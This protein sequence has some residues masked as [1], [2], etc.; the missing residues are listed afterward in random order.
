MKKTNWSILAVFLALF[1]MIWIACE[2]EEGEIDVGKYFYFD[3]DKGEDTLEVSA[4]NSFLLTLTAVRGGSLEAREMPLTVVSSD[5]V[6]RIPETV[7]FAEGA[8]RGNFTISYPAASP[9]G[10]YSFVLQLEGDGFS[11]GEG[12]TTLSRT[13]I[14]GNSGFRFVQTDERVENNRLILTK[15]DELMLS[16]ELRRTAMGKKRTAQPVVLQN[17]DAVF[18]FPESVEFMPGDSVAGI[19]V[20]FPEVHSGRDYTFRLG[21]AEKETAKDD[22]QA[23]CEM[24]VTVSRGVRFTEGGKE[25]SAEFLTTDDL[26]LS[27][28]LT[29][30]DAGE[31]VSVPV[32]T[33]ENEGDFQIPAR[34]YF[35]E[36]ET[37]ALLEITFPDARAGSYPLKI[38]VQDEE[39]WFANSEEAIYRTTVNVKEPER[40]EVFAGVRF[41]GPYGDFTWDLLK[42][43]ERY[44]LENF[45]YDSVTEDFIFSVNAAGGI[46]PEGAE[47][48]SA[49]FLLGYAWLNSWT[50]AYLYVNDNFSYLNADARSGRLYFQ[51]YVD[52]AYGWCTYDFTW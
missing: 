37:T 35:A 20:S 11:A 21:M 30:A 27:V 33:I 42:L 28:E 50:Y 34:V 40:W 4:D 18:Q 48:N 15:A 39:K 7:R 36:G 5:T 6:F 31:A 17:D 43:G 3:S 29:R 9:G 14:V 51:V 46:V 45:I 23:V 52:G 8:S 24:K 25:N 16:L 38:S 26:K 2:N 47:A 1:P 10:I 32:E 12:L 22:E 41:T 44:K 13:I 19:T 49:Q